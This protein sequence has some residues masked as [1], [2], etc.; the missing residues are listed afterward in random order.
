MAVL[1]IVVISGFVAA[2]SI[3][4]Q[5]YF[6]GEMTKPIHERNWKSEG[7]HRL[8][9][10]FTGTSVNYRDRASTP[11]VEAALNKIVAN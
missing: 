11:F 2:V 4:T 10:I 8:A 5:A 6:L 3:G 1:A 9:K 7:F